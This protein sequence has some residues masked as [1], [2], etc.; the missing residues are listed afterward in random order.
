MERL[1]AGDPDSAAI[2]V[3]RFARR[4]VAL[5]A[6][7]WPD[8]VRAKEDPEDAVQ[9]ALKSFF[10]RQRDGDL[11]A[12]DWDE[13]GSLLAYLTV[14]KVD[15]RFRY[16]VAAKRDTRREGPSV[17]DAGRSM[18]AR[19]VSIRERRTRR[20]RKRRWWPILWQP[21][22]SDCDRPIG[23]F[24]RYDLQGYTPGGDLRGP[25]GRTERTSCFEF[26]N[27]SANWS[28]E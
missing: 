16:Y 6:T 5:A 23:R 3:E 26:L 8:A 12:A 15:H 18:P 13:L 22:W 7:R 20:P 28:M 2:V 25:W 1:R 4:L 11:A 19:V 14:C 17:G 27:K 9:S 10:V 24:S 21:S